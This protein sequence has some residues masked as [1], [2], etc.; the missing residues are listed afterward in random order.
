M[1][2]PRPP[3]DDEKSELVQ[4][5]SKQLRPQASWS[6]AEEYPLALTP[7][8]FHNIRLIRENENI[9]S[10]AVM[11]PSVVKTLAG[12]FRVT[13]IG[14]VVT[15]PNQRGQGLSHRI[16]N[17]CIETAAQ[18][19]SELAI[20][21]TDLYDFYRKIGFEL[22]GREV[23]LALNTQLPITASELRFECTN[24]ID[25][26]AILRLY[27][28]H[29]CGVVRTAEDIRK[30]LNIPNARVYTAWG[31]D[32]Q[33]KAF[34]VEG[35]GIDLQGYIHEW[36]GDV[37]SLISLLSYAQSQTKEVLTVLSPAH[38]R[39]FITRMEEFGCQRFDGVLGMIRILN[40]SQFMFKIKKHF[41]SLGIDRVV[42]EYRDEQYYIGYED[43]IFKTDSGS[44]VVRLVFGPHKASDLY[45]FKGKMKEVFESTFPLPLWIWGWD[46]V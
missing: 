12:L 40:P 30:F 19:G 44:D 8:N 36:A 35:K 32:R 11:K 21:W 7:A 15:E 14:S 9:L 42:F 45:P 38:A 3:R 46:S 4:F 2:D 41:R 39:N 22:A 33:L 26:Q 20:L 16:L 27:S 10:V 25:A 34:A 31:T 6:I 28:K 23:S 17:D 24:K 5:L 1:I 37:D 43:E 18:S 29:T 13:A